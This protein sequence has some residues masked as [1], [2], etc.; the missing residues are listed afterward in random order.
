MICLDGYEWA[1]KN[2]G[3]YWDNLS[4]DTLST[5]VKLHHEEARK[6]GMTPMRMGITQYAMELIE[7]KKKAVA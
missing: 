4:I 5:I 1:Q 7:L 2:C 3:L 6:H